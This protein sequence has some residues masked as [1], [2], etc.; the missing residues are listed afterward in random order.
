MILANGDE[1][2]ESEE[3]RLFNRELS[4]LAFNRRVLAQAQDPMMPLLE[5]FKFCAIHGSNLD[6]FF[7]VR[8]AGLLDQVAAGITKPA[9]DGLSPAGQLLRIRTE[10]LSQI[11]ELEEL[12]TEV[13]WPLLRHEGVDLVTWDDLDPTEGK[14]MS[15]LFEQRVFPVL[16]PL[17]VDP[18]H[19]FPSISNLS[20]NV[21]VQVEEPGSGLRRFARIKVPPS[22]PRLISVDGDDRLIPLEELIIGHLELL[23]PGMTIIGGWPFRITRN[24]DLTVDADADDLLEAVEMELRRR[25]FGAAVRLEMHRDMPDEVLG[26]LT[27]ELELDEDDLYPSSG[28][29]DPT[30]YW[31]LI[32]L[33]RSELLLDTTPGVTPVRL[34]EVEDSRD[35]FDRIKQGDLF[36]QYP[37]DSFNAAITPFLH[38]AADDPD[39]LAIKITLYRTSGDSPI[40]D[41][42]T[43]AAENGKQVVALIELKAR[44]D[45][46]ANIGWARQL[47]N[48]GVHVV[49]GLVGLKTHSKVTLVVRNEPDGIRRYCHV[50][51]GNYNPKTARIYEDVGLLTADPVVGDD[52]TQ[53][54]NYLTGYGRELQYENLVVAPYSLRTSLELLIWAEMQAPV[55][56]GHMVLKMNSLVDPKLIDLLY[57][58]SQAGVNIDLLVRGICCLRPGVP[59]MSDNI[60][61]RSLVGRYLEHSRVYYFAHGGF[62]DADGRDTDP[63]LDLTRYYFGSADLMPRNLDRRVEVLARVDDAEAKRRLAEILVT[64][65]DDTELAWRLGP[66]GSYRRIRDQVGSRTRLNAHEHLTVLADQRVAEGRPETAHFG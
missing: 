3:V 17:A 16:T 15:E 46:Q 23:F 7:M 52:L 57:E 8:V 40:I 9:P 49:Y 10:V 22:L 31:Q 2:G 47:E 33:D 4:W 6:E 41:A 50:G 63:A 11:L 30:G 32:G 29:L 5:R 21:A 56:E 65:L 54:F 43:L 59:G 37:Y 66:D 53:L 18:A 64:C 20:L 14:L 44:F 24:A 51:T 61:V 34:R 35:M 28:L 12:Q 36:V 58:A 42:L 38:H 39:V 1:V 60:E 25:R 48:S 13:L 55:G 26:L 27:Q 62:L 45:E 19:P